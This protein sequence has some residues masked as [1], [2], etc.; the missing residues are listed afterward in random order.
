MSRLAGI[1]GIVLCGGKSSRMGQPKAWL[2]FGNEVLLQRVV[3]LLSEVVSP[4]VVVAAPDQEL[5]PLPPEIL[6]SRDEREAQGPVGGLAAGFAALRGQVTAAYVSACDVPLLKPEVVRY[7]AE[8]LGDADIAIPVDGKFPHP[9]AA[10][11]RLSLEAR[12]KELLDAGRLRPVFLWE[13]ATVNQIPIETLRDID[14]G[15]DS[16]R[17]ANTPEEFEAIRVRAGI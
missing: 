13:G 8:Q 7:I 4:I 2:P 6:V 5:P 11:Y 1:G 15:L 17:N 16:F 14:P 3:R 12:L 10:V 9:L